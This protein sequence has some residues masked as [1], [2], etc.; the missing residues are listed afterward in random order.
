MIIALDRQHVGKPHRL[1]DMGAWG[2]FDGD[3]EYSSVI[4]SEAIWTGLYLFFAELRLRELGHTVYP[5]TNG[6]Y[7][8][9]HKDAN[10]VQAGCYIAA[11]L[12]SL[13]GGTRSGQS[14]NYAAVF[15]DHRSSPE[16]G[17]ALAASIGRELSQLPAIGSKVRIWPANPNDWTKRAYSTIAGVKK[18][19]SICYEAAFLDHADHRVFFDADNPSSVAPLGI[20]LA[21]G[22][23]QWA[24]GR[25]NA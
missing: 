20:A 23:H 5:I 14:G 10:Q 4:E 3:G 18:P 7:S 17:P 8:R 19:V 11:H 25:D 24:M 13:T 1:S 6:R 2:D 12:N 9:R 21:D 15:H 16:N 22:I